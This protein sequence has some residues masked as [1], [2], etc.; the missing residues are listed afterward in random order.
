MNV[1]DASNIEPVQA[2]GIELMGE[3]PFDPF[4]ALPLESL[5]TLATRCFW[6]L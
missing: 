2:A 1:L 6:S 3:V 5:A 4:S